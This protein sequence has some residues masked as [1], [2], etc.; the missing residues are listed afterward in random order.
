MVVV[1]IVAVMASIGMPLFQQQF[2]VRETESIARR[3]ILHAQ[4]A[5]QQA[6]HL[7]KSIQ[8]A[9]LAGTNWNSGWVVADQCRE[10]DY[11][12]LCDQGL[13]FSQGAIAPIYF[14]GSAKQ[15]T[16][17]NQSQ[18]G[19]TFN[20][21]GAAKTS[22]GGFL[23]TRLILGHSANSDIERHLILSSGG[24]WR[25]CDPRLDSKACR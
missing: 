3:F 16:H 2:A 15:W 18:N 12:S 20:A 19:I 22:Q 17:Q 9:P 23:A 4:F 7:G 21:A 10:G 25:I 13:T 5:R 11:P 6:L 24:R 1:F 8:M 14:K